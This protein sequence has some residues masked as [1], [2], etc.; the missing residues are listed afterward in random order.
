MLP[1]LPPISP[2][3]PKL[4]NAEMLMRK[5]DLIVTQSGIT[6]VSPKIKKQ[7]SPLSRSWSLSSA[8]GTRKKVAAKE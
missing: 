8:S 7:P 2:D 3:T 4:R 5:G 6:N 1:R